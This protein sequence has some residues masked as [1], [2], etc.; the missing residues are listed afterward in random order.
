MKD[1]QVNSVYA[2]LRFYNCLYIMSLCNL[3]IYFRSQHIYWTLSIK[4]HHHRQ[5]GRTWVQWLLFLFLI[6]QK[7]V[8]YGG[9]LHICLYTSGK[10]AFL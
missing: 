10:Y 9:T 4:L 6:L 1:T 2:E 5:I 8:K 7:E 3:A